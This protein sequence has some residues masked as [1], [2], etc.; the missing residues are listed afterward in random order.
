MK[1]TIES[2]SKKDK[3]GKVYYNVKIGE[4]FYSCWESHVAKFQSGTTI[5]FAEE[6]REYNGKT[7]YNMKDVKEIKLPD[8]KQASITMSYAKDIVVQMISTGIISD[9][10]IIENTLTRLH[11]FMSDTL[12]AEGEKID[13]DS[14]EDPNCPF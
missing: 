10:L 12:N 6:S 14:P 1:G 4:K 5:S 2:V 3:N 8:D 9:I 11:H 13:E 7:Y